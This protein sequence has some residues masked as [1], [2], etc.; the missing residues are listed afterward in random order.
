MAAPLIGVTSN[1]TAQDG[2]PGQFAVSEKYTQAVQGAGGLPV[3]IPLGLSAEM[4]QD[5]F[6]RL[7]GLLLTGGADIAPDRFGG[8]FHP[9]VYGVNPARD[10][11]E[12][13]LVQM[14][15]GQGLPFLGICRGIQVIN[16]ALGGT[17]YTDL[18]D[19]LGRTLR[20][21]QYP[22]IPADYLAHPVTVEPGTRLEA[23]LTDETVLVNSLHHQ[24]V[25]QVAPPLQVAARAPDGLIEAVE[26][27]DHPF[28]LGVQWHPEWLQE[29]E[30]HRR[31]FRS[32]V[33]AA[34]AN[35]GA[36]S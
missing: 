16:V 29:H 4:L 22:D 23:I 13:H 32:L 33:A 36:G 25:E 21:D 26:L 15:A 20:H 10:D 27:P 3:L 34:S 8:V 30:L 5:L 17:L 28:G 19:Q 12:I 18:A 2:K 9:R 31:L 7:D 1:Y 35:P 6:D 11:L 14:A 24:G